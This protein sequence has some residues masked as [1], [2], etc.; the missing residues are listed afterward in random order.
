MISVNFSGEYF[1]VPRNMTCSKKCANP[2]F[3]GSTSLRDPV[4][5]GIWIETMFGNPVGTTITRSP[6]GSVASVA[7]NGR[8]SLGLGVTV[9]TDGRTADAAAAAVAFP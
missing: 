5:T 2:L 9:A 1:G 7:L 3:P 8:T 6:L 4:W